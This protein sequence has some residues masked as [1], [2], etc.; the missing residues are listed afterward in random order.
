VSRILRAEWTKLRTVPSTAW[1]VV[2]VVGLTLALGVA[3]VASVDTQQCPTPTTC[4]ED[5]ARLSLTGVWLGQAAVAVLAVLAVTNEH[6]SGLIRSTLAVSPS[7]VRV[8]AGR[9]TVVTATVLAAAALGVAGSVLAAAAILPANGFTPAHGYAPL[10][11]ADGPTLRAAAGS[12]LYLGLVA[13]LGVAVA[14]IVRGTAAALTA[15]LTVLYA[16]PLLVRFVSDPGWQEQLQRWSPSSAGLAIQATTG[17]D[18]L[19]I[20]PWAGLG[21]LAGYAAV[22][23]VG[24]AALFHARDAG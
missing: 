24:A 18:R 21:V 9:L 8:L 5:T 16:V 15:T 1:L 23:L 12:V 20:Q 19:P 14:T 10:S 6:A 17:L 4:A 13:M 22:A 11:L 2:A 7:R 3:A